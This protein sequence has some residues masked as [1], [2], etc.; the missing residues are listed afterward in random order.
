MKKFVKCVYAVSLTS[1][2]VFS[3]AFYNVWGTAPTSTN[4]SIG[5]VAG[6]D[7][8]SRMEVRFLQ[9]LGILYPEKAATTKDDKFYIAGTSDPEQPLYIN[10]QEYQGRT[11]NGAF[12]VEVS[13]PEDGFYQCVFRQGDVSKV[14]PIFKNVSVDPKYDGFAVPSVV[15]KNSGIID[16][17]VFPSS[18]V[19]VKEKKVTLSCMAP[20]NAKVSANFCGTTF[21]LRQENSSAEE[22]VTTKYSIEVNLESSLQDDKCYNLGAV[23]YTVEY[24][25]NVEEKTSLGK[26][27]YA[28]EELSLPKAIR[29]VWNNA[30]I[31][32]RAHIDGN[33]ISELKK[34]NIAEVIGKENGMYEIKYGDQ[35]GWVG[36]ICCEPIFD[37]IEINNEISGVNFTKNDKWEILTFKGT[38]NPVFTSNL[39][40]DKLSVKLYNTVG[41]LDLSSLRQS[42]SLFD[43]VTSKSEDGYL[44]I[45]FNLKEKDILWGYNIGIDEDNNSLA[46]E[47]RKK[48]VLSS[49]PEKPLQNISILID[50]GHGGSDPGALGL[51]GKIGYYDEKTVNLANALELKKCLEEAGA[52]VYMTRETDKYVSLSDRVGYIEDIKPDIY[53]VMHSDA[54]ATKI[55]ANGVAIHYTNRNPRSKEFASLILDKITSYTGAGNRGIKETDFYVLRF[56]ACPS[57]FCENYMVT[58][59]RDSANLALKGT[60]TAIARGIKDGV[61]ELLHS[62]VTTE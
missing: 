1:S 26:I 36:E 28:K 53:I 38:C 41:N 19:I 40:D 49:N 18:S 21:E 35:S 44:E 22:G 48:P 4:S 16:S 30:F 57:I 2:V 39:V 20:A 54:S 14:V 10:D 34:G 11:L 46:I 12:E 29:V 7:D 37:Q 31:K 58:N 59:I 24:N 33:V 56:G 9:T 60:R 43:D 13:V 3:S 6:K 42:S 45:V 50:P 61:I 17:S 32:D 8:D 55:K 15:R 25:G 47:L 5:E 52:K 23:K 51:M 62:S 27:Y